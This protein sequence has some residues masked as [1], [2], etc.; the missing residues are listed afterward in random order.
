MNKNKHG[1][2]RYIPSKV[3]KEVRQRCGFGCVICGL[4][5][6]DYEHFEPDFAEATEHSPDGI[7]LLCSQCNQKR[8]RGRLSRET[9]ALAN[10]SPKCL[11]DGVSSEF[12][13]FH[14]SPIEVVFGGA[15]FF[16]CQYLLVINGYPILKIS[17]P[18]EAGLPIKLSGLLTDPKGKKLVTILDNRFF[19]EAGTWDIEKIGA[20][21]IFRDSTNDIVLAIKLDP[22]RR[23]IIEKL[24]MMFQNIL[25]RGDKDY[26]NISLNK[27]K[28][29]I[30]IRSANI[31]RCYAGIVIGEA[32]SIAANNDI[33]DID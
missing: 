10:S 4:A 6:Y 2:S 26:L 19:L 31:S 13:D 23:I 16:D 1:L 12:F 15:K 32:N 33:Y 8:A 21:I 17:P 24:E 20:K 28:D 29:W 5:F 14:S 30:H 3:K 18:E 25:L 9:V 27:G 11:K 22:P 7:T